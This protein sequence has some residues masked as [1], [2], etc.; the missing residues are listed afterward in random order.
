MTRTEVI[1]ILEAYSK[2]LEEHGY[3]DTDWRVEP[4]FAIDEFLKQK[5]YKKFQ[6]KSHNRKTNH[7]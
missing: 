6:I 4:P 5:E 7:K 1:D 3:M 2:F